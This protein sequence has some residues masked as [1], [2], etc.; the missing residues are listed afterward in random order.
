VASDLY[1]SL[2]PC[3]IEDIVIGGRWYRIPAKPAVEWLEVLLPEHISL[4]AIIPGFLEPDASDYLM[5]LMLANEFTRDELENLFWEL[6]GI[7]A[8]RDWWT[9]LYLLVHAKAE[10]NRAI[11]AG[12]LSLLGTD[13]EKLSLAGWLDA[14]YFVFAEH[15]SNEDR[16]RFDMALAKPPPGV[17]RTIDRDTQRR[18]FAA[19]MAS[20]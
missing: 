17:K 12:R 6:V 16:Q 9:A 11:V 13:A 3:S 19:L 2:K 18:N 1:A 5:D 14:V 8:G 10:A 15:M 4:W 20:E 7:A